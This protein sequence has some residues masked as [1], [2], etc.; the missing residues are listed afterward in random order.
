VGFGLG[1]YGLPGAPTSF[2]RFLNF[3]TYFQQI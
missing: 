2:F 3:L 1:V